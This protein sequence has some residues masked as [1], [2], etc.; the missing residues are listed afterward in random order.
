MKRLALGLVVLGLAATVP[1][2]ALADRLTLTNQTQS[3][4]V[5]ETG[6]GIAVFIPDEL[7]VE[8]F[9]YTG[10]VSTAGN[11]SHFNVS[12]SGCCRVE[13]SVID[14]SE[15]FESYRETYYD[16]A[17]QYVSSS[18]SYESVTLTN[19]SSYLVG[20]PTDITPVPEPATYL[21]GL[22]G[23]FTIS[24]LVR[25]AN[26]IRCSR[27]LCQAPDAVDVNRAAADCRG[28]VARR[29]SQLAV[30]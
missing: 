10:F 26:R 1:S 16:W 30:G 7:Y 3:L 19:Y 17:W 5:R 24:T 20:N 15:S 6:H 4:S 9:A 27:A 13:M 29:C 28:W 2:E 22:A 11:S 21:L 25:R 14:H 12:P 18:S 23:L 8:W